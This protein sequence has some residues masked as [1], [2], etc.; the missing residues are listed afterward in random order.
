MRLLGFR[1]RPVTAQQIPRAVSE[2]VNLAMQEPPIIQDS[3][4]QFVDYLRQRV[5]GLIA[6][7]ERP[8][9]DERF[10]MALGGNAT[11]PPMMGSFFRI[12]ERPRPTI[13]MILRSSKP[14]YGTCQPVAC[15]PTFPRSI[16]RLRFSS[17]TF[18]LAEQS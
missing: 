14:I 12:V 8:D 2:L 18:P 4:A 11:G 3:N 9:P 10:P 1:R 6:F 13:T 5:F 7:V 17:W 15:W 16:R